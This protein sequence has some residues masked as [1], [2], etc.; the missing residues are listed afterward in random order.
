MAELMRWTFKEMFRMLNDP[1]ALVVDMRQPV[2]VM[3]G[4][5]E[6]RYVVQETS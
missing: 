2:E 5:L 4:Y 1:L 3:L 6:Y